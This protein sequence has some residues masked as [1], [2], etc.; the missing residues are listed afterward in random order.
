MGVPAAE[1]RKNVTHDRLLSGPPADAGIASGPRTAPDRHTPSM[2]PLPPRSP[3]FLRRGLLRTGGCDSG[4]SGTRTGAAQG[5]EPRR[6]RTDHDLLDRK[7]YLLNVTRR[8]GG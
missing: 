5:A 2:N 3:V 4:R 7:E 1:H 8:V 6:P